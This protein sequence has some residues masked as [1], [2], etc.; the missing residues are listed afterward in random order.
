MSA[1][2]HANS[3][4]VGDENNVIERKTT[5]RIIEN[6]IFGLDSLILLGMLFSLLNTG[7]LYTLGREKSQKSKTFACFQIAVDYLQLLVFLFN[8]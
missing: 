1:A 6:G 2:D 8:T 4:T 7:V 5:R 3:S